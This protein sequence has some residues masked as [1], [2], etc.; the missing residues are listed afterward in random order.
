MFAKGK[1]KLMP[2][3]IDGKADIKKMF[4]GKGKEYDR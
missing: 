1:L 2:H 4:S 3:A